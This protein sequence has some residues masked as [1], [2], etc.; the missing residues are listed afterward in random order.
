M[1]FK[2]QGRGNAPSSTS[3]STKSTGQAGSASQGSLF[4]DSAA[5]STR[6]TPSPAR[7]MPSAQKPAYA[8]RP[9]PAPSSRPAPSAPRPTVAPKSIERQ[10]WQGRT[11]PPPPPGSTYADY[12]EWAADGCLPDEHTAALA[13]DYCLGVRQDEPDEPS[14][15]YRR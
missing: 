15:V 7:P 10:T 6:Q 8:S 9:A 13:L 2:V 12:F 14:V 11:Q 1:A 3:P 4:T 5:P